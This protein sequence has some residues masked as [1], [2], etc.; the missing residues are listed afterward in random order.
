M[1][2][3]TCQWLGMR[4][5]VHVTV[6]KPQSP[7]MLFGTGTLT[8]RCLPPGKYVE[9]EPLQRR[10]LDIKERV[11]GEHHS[12]TA[13]ALGNLAVLLRALG[14]PLCAMWH[15]RATIGMRSHAVLCH[16]TSP[17]RPLSF[18]ACCLKLAR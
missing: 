3:A 4:S 6:Q 9:A 17:C 14:A 18:L 7:G 12:D 13:A 11:L 16:C 1:C 8:T 5:H 2:D 15:V 10:A